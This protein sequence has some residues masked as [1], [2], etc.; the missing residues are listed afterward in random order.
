MSNVA[1]NITAELVKEL[2]VEQFPQYRALNI[3][4]VK[5]SGIDNRTFHLGDNMLIRLPS[6][7]GYAEQAAKEQKWL[8]KLSEYLSVQIPEALHMGN[9]NKDYPWNWS[10]Y[11]WL[12]GISANQLSFS[13]HELNNIASDLA[14]FIRELHKAPTA[15]AP[16]GG[17]HNYY[18]GC[19]PSVYDK[20]TRTNITKLSNI[21]NG[22]TAL[23]VWENAIKS[24][25][26]QDPVWIHGD[27]ASGNILID[28]NKLAAVIDFGC[29]GAGDPACDLV[30]VWTLLRGKSREIFKEQVDLDL[31]TWARARG[32]ALWKALFEAVEALNDKST[33][34]SLIQQ[35][36]I[37]DILF[38]HE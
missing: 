13:D 5:F 18:R 9:P 11:K 37:S 2:I 32:W 25:W 36:I 29:M 6:A 17:L 28:N 34:D 23:A 38:E 20:D 3:K 27:F 16:A 30:I 15:G 12:P 24:K 31:N 14:V 33:P 10:I 35:R 8:P 26:N 7:E 4:P 1:P 19:N 21:I 22:E